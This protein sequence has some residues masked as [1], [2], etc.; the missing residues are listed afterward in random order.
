VADLVFVEN[1]NLKELIVLVLKIRGDS[2]TQQARKLAQVFP[3]F[4]IFLMVSLGAIP[5]P[6]KI[7]YFFIQ[8]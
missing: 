5:P 6:S 1:I 7:E 8:N 2:T 4:L 3:I